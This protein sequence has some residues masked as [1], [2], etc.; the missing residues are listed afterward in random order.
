[1]DLGPGKLLVILLIV[2]LVF[3]SK[4]IPELARGLGSAKAEFERGQREGDT[5][6]LETGP[7]EPRTDAGRDRTES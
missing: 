2:A 4:K 3:G 1:M 7:V 6:L 5:S